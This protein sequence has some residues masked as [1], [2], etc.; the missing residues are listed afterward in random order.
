MMMLRG[1]ALIAL[2]AGALGS[3]GMTV[4]AG[5]HGAGLV[6]RAIFAVWV[7]TPFAALAWVEARSGLWPVFTRT[8]MHCV[9]LVLAAGSLAVYGAVTGGFLK[10]KVGTVFLIF[11][12]VSWAL[13]AIAALVSIR[14]AGRH[15]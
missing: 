10:V 12:V 9:A 1:A 3:L 14:V 5:G 6:L 7:L 11:P 15:R 13:I 2:A 4:V 8:T